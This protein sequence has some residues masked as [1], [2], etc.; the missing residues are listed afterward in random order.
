MALLGWV[1]EAAVA[2]GSSSLLMLK[3]LEHT[4]PSEK[5]EFELEF[6]GF[7]T[8]YI[9]SLCSQLVLEVLKIS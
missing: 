1:A 3:F 8:N 7:E 6:E 5:L 2:V 9:L 4:L